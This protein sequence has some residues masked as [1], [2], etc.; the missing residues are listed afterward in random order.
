MSAVNE[1]DPIVCEYS[2]SEYWRYWTSRLLIPLIIAVC[3]GAMVEM[4]GAFGI[5]ILITGILIIVI[6]LLLGQVLISRNPARVRIDRSRKLVQCEYIRFRPSRWLIFGARRSASFKFDQVTLVSVMADARGL[7]RPHVSIRTPHGF[8]RLGFFMT[9]TLL[10][11]AHDALL[12][13]WIRPARQ[14]LRP[15]P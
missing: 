15:L 4:P 9:N 3:I 14:C 6:A 1:D 11:A 2:V 12:D 10:A 7:F 8:M 13:L 5:G